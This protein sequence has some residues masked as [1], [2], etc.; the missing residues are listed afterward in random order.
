M[1]RAA[2]APRAAVSIATAGPSRPSWGGGRPPRPARPG[3]RPQPWFL[4]CSDSGVSLQGTLPSPAGSK[5][6]RSL[7]CE[8]DG[9]CLCV[10]NPRSSSTDP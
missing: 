4:S 1:R 10:A 2:A 3:P 9:K 7:F 8:A 5:Q 6:P